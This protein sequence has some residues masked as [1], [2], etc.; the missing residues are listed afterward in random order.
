MFCL[1]YLL[2]L[3]IIVAFW[4]KIN[5]VNT[6]W[7]LAALSPVTLFSMNWGLVPEDCQIGEYSQ[8]S[9]GKAKSQ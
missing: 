2:V 3:G 6:L 4:I 8:K 5:L 7:I 9:K 1:N